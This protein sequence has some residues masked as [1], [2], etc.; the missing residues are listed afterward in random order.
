MVAAKAMTLMAV[1]LY[2]NSDLRAAARA[3]FDRSRGPDYQY[4]SLLGDRA[5]PLDYRK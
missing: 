3:E 5:P 1:E 2:T 4:K